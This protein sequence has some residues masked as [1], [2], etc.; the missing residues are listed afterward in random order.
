VFRHRLGWIAC[1]RNG[2]LAVGM[3]A[4]PKPI[5]RQQPASTP[6]SLP[7]D[8]VVYSAFFHFVVDLQ[9]EASQLE[10]EGKK[11]DTLRSF[12][13]T[14]S[15]L[16]DEEARKLNEIAVACVER[17]SQ[18]DARAVVLR[19]FRIQLFARVQLSTGLDVLSAIRVCESLSG[20]DSPGQY[21]R[22]ELRQSTRRYHC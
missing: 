11:G 21:I 19:L 16:N 7:P 12:V 20:L 3:M 10:D 22:S 9:K 1:R 6:R 18:E 2:L 14:Q 15:G 5:S 4:T 13:Q 17:V 8:Q